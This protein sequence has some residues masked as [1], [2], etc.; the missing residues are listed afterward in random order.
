[1]EVTPET[2]QRPRL[3]QL[4]DYYDKNEHKLAIAFFIGGFIF[5]LV[6]LDRIDSMVTIGQQI[7]YLL[8]I[9]MALMQMFFEE[10]EPPFE[11]TK[12]IFLKRWYY[13]Y[14][15]AVIHFFFGNLLNLYTIFFFKSSSLLVSFGFLGAIVFL[16][17]ANESARFKSL[18]LSFKF[19]MLALCFLAFF[20]Y[21]VPTLV[22]FIGFAVFLFSMVVGCLPLVGV[23]WWI[24]TYRPQAFEKAKSQILVPL[25]LVLIAILTLYFFK[26]IPPVPLSVQYT[27][28]YHSVE[29]VSDPEK[30][31][32]Y[33]L[34]HERPWWKFWHNG[35]QHFYAQ[36]G[37][38]VIVFFRLFGPSSFKALKK[39]GEDKSSHISVRF[40]WKDNRAGWIDQ[41]AVPVGTFVG[42]REEGFRAYVTKA[43]YQPG[44]WKAQIETT[45]DGREIGRVYFELESAPQQPRTFQYD[46][47]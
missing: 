33:K 8:V 6:T 22:G 37:D 35:D 19:G 40:F 44:S 12:M 9:L 32:V 13:D 31:R 16:L 34:G 20:A 27:G 4:R 45:N 39:E 30:G 26:L 3:H 11:T 2:A 17:V 7:V 15:T 5:D 18:G 38:K 21:I 28:V 14:R 47:Q 41:G 43:N 1:M 46:Q 24:Q 10:L 25:G 42:G 23:G 29:T 36:P